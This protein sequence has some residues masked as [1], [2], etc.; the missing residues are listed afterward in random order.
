MTCHFEGNEKISSIPPV[1]STE[2]QKAD[3]TK[4]TGDDSSH[5]EGEFS[6]KNVIHA[7]NSQGNINN[8]ENGTRLAQA[9]NSSRSRFL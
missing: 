5:E 9:N 6:H 1:G 8:D 2:D 7:N 3:H 4:H